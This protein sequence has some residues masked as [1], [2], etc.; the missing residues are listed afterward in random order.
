[1]DG[2]TSLFLLFPSPL[3]LFDQPI[4]TLF[5]P[6]SNVQFIFT[7]LDTVTNNLPRPITPDLFEH[8]MGVAQNAIPITVKGSIYNLLIMGLNQSQKPFLSLPLLSFFSSLCSSIL[9]DPLLL[10]FPVLS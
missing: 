7:F 8:I 10:S 3:P 6:R 5:T 2:T 4:D 9:T 1:M